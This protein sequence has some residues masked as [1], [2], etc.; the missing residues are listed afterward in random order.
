[1]EKMELTQALEKADTAEELVS[2]MADH[3]VEIGLND[4]KDL[5]FGA[6][7]TE[8]SEEQLE[9]VSG[10]A[11]YFLRKLLCK[12]ITQKTTGR[13]CKCKVDKNNKTIDCYDKKTGY[14]LASYDI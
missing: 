11:I 14:L 10:G 5:L 12:I 6:S 9:N 8:L 7:D 2:V 3:G 1:M 4:V 13:K